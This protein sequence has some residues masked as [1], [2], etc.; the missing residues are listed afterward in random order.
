MMTMQGQRLYKIKAMW[1]KMMT[2]WG[3]MMTMWGQ[4]MTKGSNGFNDDIERVK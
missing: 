2:M 1:S 4:I 3:N